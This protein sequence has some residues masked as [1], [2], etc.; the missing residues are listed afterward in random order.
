MLRVPR[1][2]P[3][4][5][6]FSA[7]MLAIFIV[8]VEATIV[9]TALPTIVADLGGLRYFSWVFGSYLLTQAVTIPIYGRLADFFGRKALLIVA[10]VVFLIGSILCGFA[11]SM[12]AL[13][14][15]RALQ[16]IGAGGVQPVSTTIVGDLYQGRDRARVQGYLS[17]AWAFAAVIGPLLGAFLIAHFGWPIIFWINVPVGLACIAVVLR[18]YH[19]TI[20]RVAHRIDYLGSALLTLGIGTLMY[21]LVDLG[22]MAPLTATLLAL[23]GVAVL[24]LLLWHETRAPEPMMP[25]VLYRIRVIAVANAGNV[26][27]GAM[28]MGITAF[29]PT[30]VQG[31]LGAPAVAAGS[32]LGAFFVGWTCGSIGGARLQLRHSYRTIAC[33]GALPLLGGSTLIA[34]LH[35]GSSIANVYAGLAFLGLGFGTFNSIFVVS[36]QGAVA[37]EMR[38]AATSSL[39]FMRQIGQ[40]V[41]TAAFGAIFNIG[42]YSRLADASGVMAQLVDPARRGLIPQLDLA[43]DAD[44][45][46]QSL[47][48]V[49]LIALLLAVAISALAL[50]LPPQLRSGI[51][52]A[53][54]SANGTSNTPGEP[55]ARGERVGHE[56]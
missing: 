22:N 47:H 51:A 19:E 32:V 45:V 24:A 5:V 9:A 18:A 2:A 21:V 52:V 25:L 37:W 3:R 43:R 33:L 53:R 48:G 35:A 8:A 49:Y 10:V 27:I 54:P 38:G 1:I 30:F 17:T 34:M 4:E 16:G 20:A 55:G 56:A 12:F 23:G 7:M 31:A 6:V 15:F 26:F 46:A 13:I 28:V 42:I 14:L 40:A 50:A 39:I 29:M 11:H 44:A 36:T 41:G